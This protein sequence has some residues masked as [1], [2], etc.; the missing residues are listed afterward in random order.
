MPAAPQV[1]TSPTSRCAVASRVVALLVRREAASSVVIALLVH[2]IEDS[3]GDVLPAHHEAS[4]STDLAALVHPA[5]HSIVSLI[6]VSLIVASLIVASLIVA[7]LV[8]LVGQSSIGH[9]MAVVMK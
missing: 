3:S 2:A 1:V 8:R 9:G 5:R 7:S 6:V 4:G